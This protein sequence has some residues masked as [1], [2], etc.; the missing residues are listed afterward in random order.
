MRTIANYIILE[1]LSEKGS[2]SVYIAKHKKLERKTLLKVYS[3][4][5][6]QLIERFE[7]E[8]KIVADLNSPSIV[9]IYD[10]G[11]AEGKFFI[12][13]EFVEGW[14]LTDYLKQNTLS[15]DQILN[16]AVQITRS[17]AILH[18]KGYIHRDLKPDNILVSKQKEIKLTDFGI[19]LH[20][21][22]NRVTSEGAL[23]GTPLYMSPEQIN[24]LEL[25][26]ASD[27]FSIGVIF[28]QMSTGVQPFEAQQY[29]QVFSKILSY[30]PLSLNTLRPDLPP[31]FCELVD[32]LLQKDAAKRITDAA[33]ILKI[34]QTHTTQQAP[35]RL[36][37]ATD[38]AETKPGIFKWIFSAAILI[39][40][41]ILFIVFYPSTHPA[42]P[43]AGSDSTRADSS[44]KRSTDQKTSNLTV[45]PAKAESTALPHKSVTNNDKTL[46][47]NA[48]SEKVDITKPT[49]LMV[50][51]YPWSRVYIN[52]KFIDETP[53]SKPHKLK[54]GRYLLGLQNPDYPS[55]ADSITILAHKQNLYSVHLDSFFVRLDLKVSPWGNVYIDGKFIGTWPQQKTIY[56]T[57]EKHVLEIKNKFYKTLRDTLSAEGKK[58]IKKYIILKDTK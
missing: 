36:P 25:T 13:M 50:E 10:F 48:A 27:V 53:M 21:S 58:E 31:W 39:V 32:R 49:T 5:D 43:I 16:F 18:R 14:N 45:T 22:L 38:A 19:T 35:F 3:G 11:E 44:R 41:V 26:P 54:P 20:E 8:A 56:L 17:V 42:P 34:M 57:K 4:G 15:P 51:T 40:S 7:R 55:F 12:S 2:A 29:A 37:A 33:A 52:Y 47:A 6:A 9:S 24:N 23:L 1:T 28:Y 30:D 46:T